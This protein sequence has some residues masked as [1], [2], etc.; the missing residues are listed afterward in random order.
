[1]MDIDDILASV[2]RATNHSSP[3]SVSIDHQHLTRLW[4]AERAVSELLP[5]P[6]ELMD[7]MMERVENIEDL[8]ASSYEMSD[9]I[10]TTT[11]H[12]S[13]GRNNKNNTL[14]LKLSILQTDLSRT[15]YLIRSY[16]RQ[17]LSKITKYAMHYLVQISPPAPSSATQNNDGVRTEDTLPNP[18]SSSTGST[19]TPLSSAEAQFLYSHQYLLASHYR[20]SFLASFPPQLRRL[21]DNA[22]G[23]SMIQGP[24]MREVVVV[25]CL[26]P[27]AAVVI[28]A[29]EILD[30]ERQGDVIMRMGEVWVGRWE[31]VK[32][33]WE[34]G[35]VE[36]L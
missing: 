12:N 21:D 26:V 3:E 18:S 33:A 34:R 27:E 13:N 6:A 7:R 35:D 8:T 25:R 29:D 5:W 22:G 24:D 17:R 11:T 1:M 30:R 19:T 4:V 32:G 9:N 36:I 20:L 2:D 14:N 10:D 28:P 16:L 31:G 23:T 15:Q